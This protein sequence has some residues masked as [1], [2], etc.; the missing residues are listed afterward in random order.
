[1]VCVLVC[2]AVVLVVF[3][4]R[5]RFSYWERRGVPAPKAWPFFGNIVQSFTQ[6]KTVGQIFREIYHTYDTLPLVGAYRANEPVLI[7]RDPELISKILV[8]DSHVFFNNDFSVDPKLDAMQGASPFVQKDRQWKTTRTLLSPGF[9]SGKMKSLF[10]LIVNVNQRLSKYLESQPN[11]ELGHTIETQNLCRRFTLDN[12]ALSAFGIDGKCFESEESDF[13]RLAN[14]FIAPGSF[15]LSMLQM[16][17]LISRLVALKAIPKAVED[18]LTQIITDSLEHRKKNKVIAS[19]Y[20]QFIAQLGG[21]NYAEIAGHAATFFEDGYE[22]SALVMS[23][24]LFNLSRHQEVQARL[25]AEIEEQNEIGHDQ[26]AKMPY[27]NACLFESMRICPVL[28]HYTRVCSRPYIYKTPSESPKH[29]Q[30][31]EVNI[32]AGTVCFVPFGGLCHDPVYFSRPEAFSPER[33]LDR[34]RQGFKRVFYPFGGGH[35]VCLG[36]RFGAM[37][38]KMGIVEIIRR[39]QVSFDEKTHLP[40]AFLPWTVLN[41]VKGGVWLTYRKL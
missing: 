26:L 2:L 9:T 8:K 4:I 28:E 29:L 32:D 30:R 7:V 22:T 19:D 20:L 13:M 23:Y 37:Q 6:Q 34:D 21:L 27:L 5:R 41:K 38:V 35:R 1:M 18:T 17:P 14:S 39:F 33:F 3:L 24:L 36:Q 10:P 25:R 11:I 12:V 31:M 40:F 15:A 16:F